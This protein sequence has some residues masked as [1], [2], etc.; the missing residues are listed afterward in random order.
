MS[1]LEIEKLA[2]AFALKQIESQIAKGEIKDPVKKSSR[3]L[4]AE[5]VNGGRYV[6]AFNKIPG[7]D[8]YEKAVLACHSALH[9]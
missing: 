7:L 8:C 3:D 9:I 4:A 6:R 5:C 2:E 1:T